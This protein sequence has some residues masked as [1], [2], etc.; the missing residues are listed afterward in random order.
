MNSIV[1]LVLVSLAVFVGTVN[2]Q[3]WN[4]SYFDRSYIYYVCTELEPYCQTENLTNAD[5]IAVITP[6]RIVYTDT[7]RRQLS[8][9][10]ISNIYTPT[11]IGRFNLTGTPTSITTL[12][13]RY[14]AVAVTRGPNN[15]QGGVDLIDA[16]DKVFVGSFNLTS[17]PPTSITAS[18][19]G[20]KLCVASSAGTVTIITTSRSS[21]GV[22]ARWAKYVTGLTAQRALHTSVRGHTCHVTLTTGFAVIDMDTNQVKYGNFDTEQVVL[23]WID[24]VSD[25]RINQVNR[26]TTLRRP[27]QSIWM[28]SDSIATANIGSNGMTLWNTTTLEP[29]YDSKSLCDIEAVR[30]G[31]YSDVSFIFVFLDVRVLIE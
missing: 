30:V 23:R 10:N 11:G 1:K 7:I 20:K 24:T 16:I 17:N 21:R 2:A 22:P 3:D 29:I 18:V 27:V 15:T 9:V 8:I 19:D 28:G 5:K 4:A 12:S 6:E 26:N 13:E 14:A 31:H 25:G